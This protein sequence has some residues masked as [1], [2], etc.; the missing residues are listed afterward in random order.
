MDWIDYYLNGMGEIARSY[1]PVAWPWLATW[2]DLIAT[3]VCP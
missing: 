1:S 2:P 3:K